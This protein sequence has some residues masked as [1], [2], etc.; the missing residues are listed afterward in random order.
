M[1]GFAQPSSTLVNVA[2][3]AEL[4]LV[5]LMAESA[6]KKK[7]SPKFEADCE[8]C[9]SN[10]DAP[11]LI[12][13]ILRD[14]G[15]M[16]ALFAMDPV[17]DA[18]SAFTILAALL[19][20]VGADRPGEEAGLAAELAETV[21][22]NKAF[23]AGKRIA[24][25][26]ALY[27]LRTDGGEKCRLL[28]RIVALSAESDPKMLASGHALG[29]ILEADNITSLVSAWN[30]ASVAEHR[31]LL[32]TIADGVR[33]MGDEDS[34]SRNQRFLLLLVET[35][36][37]ESEV[38]QAGLEAAKDATV[39]AIRDPVKLVTEQRS[40]LSMTA[41]QALSKNTETLSL[42][43]LLQVFQEGKLEDYEAFVS[44]HGTKV[45]EKNGLN[46][47]DCVRYM[48]LLSLCSLAAEH[49]EIPYAAI[50]S[51]LK[52]QPEEVESWVI[53]AV[54][55]G[56]LLAKMDQLQQVVMVERCVVRRFGIEEW[57]SLQTRLH[58]WKKNVRGVLEGLKQSQTTV[59][60]QQ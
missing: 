34:I 41:V 36:T 16:A 17:E 60:T 40:M 58:T 28:T 10:A 53:T 3:H 55:S 13:T 48:R 32:R 19:D 47:E 38:D 43:S 59:Q 21:G 7:L 5:R 8:A 6:P 9:I 31:A 54:S 35:Y 25:L 12:R 49:E 1:S 44:K 20:R 24:M 27:N 51:T 52:V 23:D 15:A 30:T 4:T 57:K 56:L 29:S 18:I 22:S 50:V 42:Y 46:P 37:D 39:G 11:A 26:C 33:K 45:L 2:E 14:A